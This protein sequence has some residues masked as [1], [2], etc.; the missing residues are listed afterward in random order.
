M[1]LLQILWEGLRATAKYFP[2]ALA[3][4]PAYMYEWGFLGG[5]K[6]SRDFITVSWPAIIPALGTVATYLA[7][8][9]VGHL[10]A[11]WF[12]R[13]RSETKTWLRSLI[14]LIMACV[15]FALLCG[16]I[17]IF[18]PS[19]W[20]TLHFAFWHAHDRWVCIA[21][22]TALVMFYWMH[23][24]SLAPVDDTEAAIAAIRQV[25]PDVVIETHSDKPRPQAAERNLFRRVA[26]VAAMLLVVILLV[27]LPWYTGKLQAKTQTRFWVPTY[28][29]ST[30]TYPN[31]VVLRIYGD[32]LVCGE[33]KELENGTNQLTGN[34][35]VIR[36]DDNPRP[37][38]KLEKK[39]NLKLPDS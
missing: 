33:I 29:D 23:W 17:F 27:W 24:L 20:S 10:A 3:F 38:L 35:F 31:S 39:G 30:S 11:T 6:L 25:V 15:T 5:F 21:A 16:W 13:R 32:R 34:F 4:L 22:V 36:L 9:V 12:R 2:L 37:V 7:I 18:L 19:S 8:A 26:V 1:R 14:S 28:P